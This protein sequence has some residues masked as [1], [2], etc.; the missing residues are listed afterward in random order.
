MLDCGSGTVSRLNKFVSIDDI[1]AVALSHLHGDHMADIMVLRYMHGYRRHF[2]MGDKE[3]VTVFSPEEPGL[4]FEYIRSVRFFDVRPVS[5][6]M[7]A[8][9]G[10]MSLEF[11][12]ME[13]PY[14]SFGVRVECEGKAFAY[15]G[16]TVM[17]ENIAP[18]IKDADLFLC[19]SSFLEADRTDESS[20]LSAAQAAALSKE[21]GV[22]R[23]LLTHR[24]AHY[25]S[26]ARHLDEAKAI[27]EDAEL[28]E[29]MRTYEF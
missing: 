5:H 21:N 15:S 14:P 2:G 22:K 26:A 16:D 18:M 1:D 3:G 29:E 11:Y 20:H 24:L 27:F 10:S 23:L 28:T 4:E 7:K 6:A 25:D 19:D 9:V 17:N 8:I 13:H 12:R